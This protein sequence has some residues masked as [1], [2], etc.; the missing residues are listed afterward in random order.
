ML[1]KKD[2]PWYPAA[3]GTEEPFMTRTG[4]RLLYCWQPRTGRPAYLDL[5][6]DLIL[7]DEEA[8]AALGF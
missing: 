8:N 7:S 1:W 2:G 3:N 4:R 5:A 6:T